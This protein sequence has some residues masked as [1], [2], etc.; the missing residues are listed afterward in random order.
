[1]QRITL[2][3]SLL[4]VCFATTIQAQSTAPRPGSEI[5]KLHV[6]V[7]H[8]T[9]EGVYKPGPLGPGGKITGTYDARMILGGFFLQ[10]EEIE[11]GDA[12]E[13]RNL[14]VESYNPANKNFDSRWYQSDGSTVNGTLTIKG[15]TITLA[16]TLYVDGNPYQFREPMV[17]SSDFTTCP[18]KAEISTDG[19]TWVPFFETTFIKAKP[20]AKK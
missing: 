13:L 8:W 11:K 2:L 17:C 18:A 10:E 19:K 12:G 1:M 4:V 7:G 3:F 15:N 5:K 16:G 9:Y 20:A 6:L 14:G